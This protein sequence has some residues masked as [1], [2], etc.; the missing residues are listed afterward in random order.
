MT[1]GTFTV[2]LTVVDDSGLAS[3]PVTQSVFINDPPV[4]AFTF[5]KN[6]LVVAFDGTGSIDD[7]AVTTYRWN[8]NDSSAV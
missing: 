3:S 5:T 7:N 8:W 6:F 1:S 4:A 2:T